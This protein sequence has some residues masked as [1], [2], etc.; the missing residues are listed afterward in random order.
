MSVKGLGAGGA[1]EAA[2]KRSLAGSPISSIWNHQPTPGNFYRQLQ[3][4]RGGMQAAGGVCSVDED[5]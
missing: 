5:R 2:V 3:R 4:K 1:G